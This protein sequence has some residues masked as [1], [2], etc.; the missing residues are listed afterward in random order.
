MSAAKG[1]SGLDGK[2]HGKEL[3]LGGPYNPYCAQLK[4][5]GERGREEQRE[6]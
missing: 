4:N 5:S 1:V 6:A 2:G 3:P